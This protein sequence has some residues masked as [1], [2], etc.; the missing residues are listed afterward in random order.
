ML[1]VDE[2]DVDLLEQCLREL[3][4]IIADALD[5]RQCADEADALDLHEH[6]LYH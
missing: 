2:I 3:E 6:V 1:E 4:T 5:R